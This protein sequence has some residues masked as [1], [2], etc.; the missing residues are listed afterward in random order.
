M[1]I[2]VDAE[3]AFDKIQH[4]FM[5]K[6]SPE[7]G[8]RGNTAQHH[9][10]HTHVNKEDR[11]GEGTMTGWKPKKI[12]FLVADVTWVFKSFHFSSES[13]QL[14]FELYVYPP[15]PFNCA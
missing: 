11:L 1:I 4:P 7:S 15:L 6:N 9:K 5:I 10:N 13:R 8:H 14:T 3:K 12:H 2:S